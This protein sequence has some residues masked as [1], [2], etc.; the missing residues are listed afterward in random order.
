MKLQN[1]SITTATRWMSLTLAVVLITAWA[2]TAAIP[3]NAQSDTLPKPGGVNVQTT[4]GSLEV[5]VTWTSV[6]GAASYRVRLRE[7]GPDN[8]F[9]DVATP[10][11][12]SATFEAGG[13]GDWVVRV[14]ACN[15][16]GCGRGTAV[17]F[18]VVDDPSSA[19]GSSEPTPTPEPAPQSAATGSSDPTPTPEPAPQS[20]ASGSS[21]PEPAPQSSASGSTGPTPTPLPVP[22]L[23]I[24]HTRA[25]PG[26]YESRNIDGGMHCI[27]EG[28]SSDPYEFKL[29]R[30]PT[31]NVTVQLG[32]RYQATNGS[33]G[34]IITASPSTLTFTPSNWSTRQS[35]TFSAPNDPDAI[36]PK[37]GFVPVVSSTDPA[38]NFEDFTIDVCATDDDQAGYEFSSTSLSVDEGASGSYTIKL[39][40]QPGS[41][42][43]VTVSS[44]GQANAT[45]SSYTRSLT[46]TRANW[47][48]AQSITVT[49][50]RD[51]NGDSGTVTISHNF[52]SNDFQYAGLH[53]PD[54][55]I[56]EVEQTTVGTST[57][58]GPEPLSLFV[59]SE[60][61]EPVW[62]KGVAFSEVL[63][64]AHGGTGAITY[65]LAGN[66]PA[67]V[68]FNAST[69][70]IS[71]TP[72]T[73]TR[74]WTFLT[75]KAADSATPPN[76]V[77]VVLR[78]LVESNIQFS[79][80]I[81]DMEFTVGQDIGVVQLPTATGCDGCTYRVLPLR[82]QGIGRRGTT[83]VGTPTGP[84]N[85]PVTVTYEAADSLGYVKSIP[86]RITVNSPVRING[87]SV[88]SF[89]SGVA[90]NP[91]HQLP[92]ATGGTGTISYSI[93][94]AGWSLPTG[95]TFDSATRSLSGT[96]AQPTSRYWMWYQATDELGSTHR[97]RVWLGVD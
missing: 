74:M 75:Y 21:E 3:V 12:T 60:D 34:G 76:S 33:D 28:M 24:S 86:F 41:D 16:N 38:Y 87:G 77:E 70:T 2:L 92:A 14:E 30:Q 46:F 9:T 22:Y 71:G 25:N 93:H 10:T 59:R 52:E 68:T 67:G 81:S 79:A 51:S 78:Y 96:P 95:V 45:V 50:G 47:N 66:L 44:T 39:K 72:T 65:T 11:N 56:T 58:S 18:T 35:V 82:P 80:T 37:A 88:P 64:A 8:S 13:F 19:S 69:R 62:T 73:A 85:G 49:L 23:D 55:T 7:A 6:S 53:L 29:P 83:L 61:Q 84:T 40:S 91:S 42:V 4:Q 97:E 20:A 1:L 48:T 57:R 5:S 94:R 36:E 89:R 90:I 32:D 54:V 27:R 17:Q 15:D 63:P 31:H 26:R 43:T